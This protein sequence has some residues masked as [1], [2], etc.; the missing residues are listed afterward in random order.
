MSRLLV[1]TRSRGKQNEFRSLLA[2]IGAELVF[3][4][5]IQIV[6]SREEDDLERY[7]TFEANARAKARWFAA[8]SGLPALADDSG[9][10]VD[11]LGGAP[12]VHSK[13]FA[14]VDGPDEL[15]TAANNRLLIARLAGVPAEQ[16]TARYRCVLVLAHV[17][18]NAEI[19]VSGQCNGM[20]VDT[21][22]GEGGFGYDPLFYSDELGVT[23]G[24]AAA[25]AKAAVSHRGR[26]V[27][28]LV[29]RLG[30]EML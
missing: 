25:D 28:A 1:A 24:E 14:G 13:R 23:F 6:P 16:R 7:D 12:G 19:E 8:R 11:A 10:E 22:R 4:D 27:A 29:E 20:I 21:P 17:N 18:G 15:V 3:P 30:R 2:P 5:D 9:L 26:A